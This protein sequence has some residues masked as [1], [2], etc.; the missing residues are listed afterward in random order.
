V[1]YVQQRLGLPVA[2]IATLSDLLQYL[3]A[4]ADAGLRAHLGAVSAYRE[5]Y[6]V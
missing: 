5:R 2:A 6:G 4:T 3:N 1:Q